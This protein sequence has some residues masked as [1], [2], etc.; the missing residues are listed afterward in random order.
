MKKFIP[1]SE[2]LS[3][4]KKLQNL[5]GEKA[6]YLV[7]SNQFLTRNNSNQFPFRQ[8]SDF[9]Y[10][11]GLDQDD[12]ALII[13]A[14]QKILF[15]SDL[16]KTKQLWQGNYR[17]L[18]EES[19]KQAICDKVYD[20]EDLEKI[21]AE[22]INQQNLDTCYFNPQQNHY[23]KLSI[24]LE[25]LLKA[26]NI[27]QKSTLE[28]SGILRY[29]KSDWEIEQLQKANKINTE[30]HKNIQQNISFLP[31]SP[32]DEINLYE[33]QIQAE[34]LRYY[35]WHG[36]DWSYWPIVAGGKNANTL[37]YWKN[38]QILNP[39]DLL[40]LD[41]GCEYN[42]YA[43]DITSTFPLT[44]KF[45]QK[46]QEVYDLVLEVFQKCKKVA[47]NYQ[48][49]TL[50]LKDLQNFSVDLLSQGLISIGIL[51]GEKSKIIENGDYKKYYP[52]GLSHWI[53]L[54]VHDHVPYKDENGEYLK[55]QKGTCFSI[56]PGIYL[57]NELGI[58]IEET[59][60]LT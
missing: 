46:Q 43:S 35:Y 49:E 10:F 19:L 42:Y 59:I 33:Y 14:S 11:T 25:N 34:M 26:K 4:Q 56:E 48:K 60:I 7:L 36:V 5:L 51:K 50:T 28:V 12:T 18:K 53:G 22:L 21:L 9:W 8:H 17:L 6:F 16:D 29:I 1:I 3:R 38:D 23:T 44:G 54:D 57:E 20:F 39:K 41:A 27:T 55:I 32:E 24:N 52:H 45:S 31:P 58:R 37:H 2:I 13:T 30:A 15:S 47:L 40:L